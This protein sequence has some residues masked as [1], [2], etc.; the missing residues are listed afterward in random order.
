M[1]GTAMSAAP[2]RPGGHVAARVLVMG[3]GSGAANNLIASLASALPALT[4]VGAHDDPFIL[5]KSNAGRNY[6]LA[7]GADDVDEIVRVVRRGA[8][9]LGIPSSEDDFKLLADPR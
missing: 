7:A 3:A 1:A 6:L 8:I 2:Y 9:D 5:R 4:A